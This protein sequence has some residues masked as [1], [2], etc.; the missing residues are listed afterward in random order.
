M[1]TELCL[2]YAKNDG[3]LTFLFISLFYC[4]ANFHREEIPRQRAHRKNQQMHPVFQQI[5]QKNGKA[6]NNWPEPEPR[7]SEVPISVPNLNFIFYI[8]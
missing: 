4:L 6:N 7:S 1:A 3:F 8:G 5:T 2:F